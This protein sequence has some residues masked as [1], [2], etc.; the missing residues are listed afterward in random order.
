M[1]FDVVNALNAGNN[2]SPPA[3]PTTAARHFVDYARR[4]YQHCHAQIM[5][6]MDLF[7]CQ[8]PPSTVL[9]AIVRDLFGENSE[10]QRLVSD[11]YTRG[12]LGACA[13]AEG[14]KRGRLSSPPEATVSVYDTMFV[15]CALRRFVDEYVIGC[16][17]LNERVSSRMGEA[18]GE[19]HQNMWR[20]NR[21]FHEDLLLTMHMH[22]WDRDVR[23][24]R[25][26]RLTKEIQACNVAAHECLLLSWLP[27][28]MIHHTLRQMSSS[29][30][31][32]RGGSTRQRQR[33]NESGD[34]D[35]SNSLDDDVDD[36]GGYE[37]EVAAATAS[38]AAARS[39]A[40]TAA[41]VPR[42]T[43]SDVSYRYVT[44]AQ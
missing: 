32:H 7:D 24:K 13:E 28:S 18:M 15:C 14:E 25:I 37:S 20:I 12:G 1:L 23:V 38:A 35:G 6:E 42:V 4:C 30:P 27:P 29:S 10:G 43:S 17:L 22:M 36:D 8:A 26:A 21:K 3:L 44:C 5:R 40:A 34:D 41:I 11:L 39:T 2:V 33:E 31:P 9:L 19:F 16:A